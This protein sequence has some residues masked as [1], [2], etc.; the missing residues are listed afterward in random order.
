[1]T[2][3]AERTVVVGADFSP[4][5]DEAIVTALRLLQERFVGHVHLL[6]V[7]DDAESPILQTENEVLERAPSLLEER[8][9]QLASLHNLRFDEERVR[10]HVRIGPA[11]DTLLQMTVDYDA[12]LL[13]VGTHGRR[14]LD[15][16]LLG[17]VAEALVRKGRCPVLV[18]RPKDYE[19]LTKTELPDPPYAPGEEPKR[20]PPDSSEYRVVSTEADTWHPSPDLP[21]GFRIV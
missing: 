11:V 3:R 10:T 21:T 20:P 8:A 19:G 16:M 15:R 18:T 14:G 17:S 13:V 4:S 6:H 12:D 9:R 1:M 7:L 2:E 5:S